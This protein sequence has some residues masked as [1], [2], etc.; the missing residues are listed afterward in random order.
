MN[1]APKL[2]AEELMA[3]GFTPIPVEALEDET[4]EEDEE[5]PPNTPMADH[6]ALRKWREAAQ[7]WR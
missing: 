6:D 3:Q 4:W 5:F 7:G 2:T 1:E